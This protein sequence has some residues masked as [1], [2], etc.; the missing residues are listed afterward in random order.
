[1]MEV[2]RGIRQI[3]CYAWEAL[4]AGKASADYQAQCCFLLSTRCAKHLLCDQVLRLGG[5]LCWQGGDCSMQQ[6]GSIA[7]RWLLLW[8]AMHCT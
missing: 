1:M 8:G 7:W 5:A 3:K 6:N 2:L 4:F